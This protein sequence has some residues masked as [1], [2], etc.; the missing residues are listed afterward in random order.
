MPAPNRMNWKDAATDAALDRG[1]T[2]LD[3]ATRFKAFAQVQDIV[4]QN[5][6]WVPLVHQGLAPVATKRNKTVRVPHRYGAAP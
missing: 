1:V 2:A 3:D 5:A 4:H 6:L